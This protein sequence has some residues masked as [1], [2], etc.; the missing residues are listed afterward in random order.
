MQAADVGGFQEGIG[1]VTLLG[2]HPD[3]YLFADSRRHSYIPYGILL[4]DGARGPI[5]DRPQASGGQENEDTQKQDQLRPERYPSTVRFDAASLDV[6]KPAIREM[7]P[8]LCSGSG[9]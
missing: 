6:S 8:A 2:E 5:R 4:N 7:P 3:E 9:A 1:A